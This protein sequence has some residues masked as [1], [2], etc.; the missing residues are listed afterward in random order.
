M[1]MG[2]RQVGKSALCASIA[3]GEHPAASV[4][5]DDQLFLL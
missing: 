4:S 2:A 3:E 5:M 1:V